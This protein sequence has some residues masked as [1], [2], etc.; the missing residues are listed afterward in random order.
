MTD[1]SIKK[2]MP[3]S[4]EQFEAI[5]EERRQAILNGS[6][7]LFALQG[8]NKTTMDEIS[9]YVECSHG[10]L[11]HYYPTKDGLFEELLNGVIKE[12]QREIINN[13][14]IEEPAKFLIKD[15]LDAYLSALKNENDEY[16]CVIYLL[17]NIHLQK[18]YMPKIKNVDQRFRIGDLFIN[19]IEKGKETA[20]FKNDNTRDLVIAILAML[21]GLA[22]SRIN[23]G[24]KDFRCPSSEII[25]RMVMGE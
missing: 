4:K 7:Y 11:Y 15:L 25:S 9:K 5:K 2:N 16:A 24:A 10:L 22:F 6:L 14:D 8:Y 20:V 3:K 21:K 19:A 17:L 13:I 18:K 1:L 12:K 23:M